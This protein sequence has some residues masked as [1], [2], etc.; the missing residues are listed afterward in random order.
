MKR[1]LPALALALS[2]IAAHSASTN[3]HSASTNQAKP[4]VALKIPQTGF[5]CG[6]F[7]TKSYYCF[8]LPVTTVRNGVSTTGYL[9]TD[10]YASLFGHTGFVYLFNV[11]V[12]NAVIN[13]ST[14]TPDGAVQEN[15]SGPNYTGKIILYFTTKHA[16]SGGRGGGGCH[17]TWTVLPTSYIQ[18]NWD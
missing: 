13:S 9:W 15:I 1:T 10:N 11:P 6:V 2:A 7:N 14:S 16:C 5:N 4:T 3:A 18:I 17:T 8:G 12:P